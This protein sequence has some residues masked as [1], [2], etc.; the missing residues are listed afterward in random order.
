MPKRRTMRKV[1]SKSFRMSKKAMR[2]SNKKRV[3][4]TAKK[5]GKKKLS[6]WNKQVAATYKSLKRSN[7]NATLGDAMK[8][9]SKDNKNNRPLSMS[10]NGGGKGRN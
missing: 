6:S 8:K 7:P 5:K 3:K 9:A 2:R 4:K 10:V 1:K